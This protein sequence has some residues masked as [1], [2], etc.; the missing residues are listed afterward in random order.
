MLLTLRGTPFIY[1]GEEIGMTGAKPDE[2]IRTPMR[3]DASSPAA[4]F[5]THA[6]WETLSDDP[7]TLNVA[8]ESADP[9]SLLSHYRDLIRLRADHPALAT[10]TWTSIDTDAPG[11][12]A[13]LRSSPTETAIVI[14]N[15]GTTAAMPTL[16][17]ATGPLCGTPMVD[18]VLGQADIA[19]PTITAAG[20]LDG[21]RP[22]ETIP[23][24]SSLVIVL[25]R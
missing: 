15:A 14:T 25:G 2:R 3:W 5:S 17:L 1:Y 8:T 24:R 23:P 6:P 22:V 11:V 18:E 10:G 16:S 9:G 13:A 12:V 7:A 4:G 19:T 21:Y 20:G